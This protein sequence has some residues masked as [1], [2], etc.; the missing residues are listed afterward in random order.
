MFL[1]THQPRLDE[2]GRLV[3][4]AKFREGLADGVVMTKGQDR[5]IVVWPAADFAAHAA[6]LSELSRT[7]AKVRAHLRVLFSG[8]FDETPDK[9]GRVTVPPQLRDY[10]GLD[11]DVVVV[12]AGQTVEI[13]EASAWETYLASQ[14]EA[15]S[16]I[17]EEVVP[18]LL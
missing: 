18:G 8:A 12:G 6:R 17:S 2:K 13:W 11:R 10:A 5:S 9:Q 4:P 14:E 1:G 7:D 3:L 16:S 15:F